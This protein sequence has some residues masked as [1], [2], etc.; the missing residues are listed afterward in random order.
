M[1]RHRLSWFAAGLIAV[2]LSLASAPVFAASVWQTPD[3]GT[4]EGSV[5]LCPDPTTAIAV[6][7]NSSTASPGSEFQLSACSSGCTASLTVQN[8]AYAAGNSEGGLLT[9]TGAARINGGTGILSGLTIRS[10]GGSTN[11][12]WVYAWSKHPVST[13]T[14]KSAFAL[15]ASDKPYG[16]PGFPQSVTLGGAPGA[17][18]DTST[19]GQVTVNSPLGHFVN[20]DTSLGTAIYLCLVTGGAVTPAATSDLS[21]I[22]GGV[23]D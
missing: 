15:S 4:V 9:L 21:L 1:T 13:C 2:A 7:C 20:Q 19:Y 16:I 12:V 3:G 6:P 22:A 5:P 8:A 17:S 18:F 14:D 11:T 23:K 10:V